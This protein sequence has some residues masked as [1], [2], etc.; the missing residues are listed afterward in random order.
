M[1]LQLTTKYEYKTDAGH[2]LAVGD[3]VEYLGHRPGGWVNI[4][5]VDGTEETAHPRAFEELQ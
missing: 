2:L 4:R 1:T 3:K 5:L